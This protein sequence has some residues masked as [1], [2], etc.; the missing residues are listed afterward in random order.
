VDDV[1]AGDAKMNG[2]SNRNFHAVRN[3]KILL[4]KD[5]HGVGAVRFSGCAEIAFNKF[6]CE[7]QSGGIE[8]TAASEEAPEDLIYHVDTGCKEDATN[9][10]DGQRK[11]DLSPHPV[12]TLSQNRNVA[13]AHQG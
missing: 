2:N 11:Y 4:G 3:E 8:A 6:S 1:G 7:V 13:A 12:M 5:A 9:K 10:N